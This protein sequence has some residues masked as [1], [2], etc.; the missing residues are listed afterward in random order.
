MGGAQKGYST[1]H[2]TF[3]STLSADD[4]ARDDTVELSVIF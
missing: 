2:G 3:T 4:D 1:P